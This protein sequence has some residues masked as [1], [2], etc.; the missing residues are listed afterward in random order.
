MR[1]LFKTEEDA[2]KWVSRN[3]AFAIKPKRKAKTKLI[4]PFTSIHSADEVVNHLG[5]DLFNYQREQLKQRQ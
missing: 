5:K 3:I 4:Y 1:Q 2:I